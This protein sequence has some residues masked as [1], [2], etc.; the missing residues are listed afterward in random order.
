[1]NIGDKIKKLRINKGLTQ[2][3]L[4]DLC[5][6]ADS[7]IRRYESGKVTPK[8]N[9][10]KKLSYALDISINEL[11]DYETIQILTE[12]DEFE[13]TYN[14]ITTG[15]LD[16]AIIKLLSNFNFAQ[17]ITNQDFG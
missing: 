14:N 13:K 9:T 5:G 10:L 2:K 15:N 12:I 7:A 11:A 1:M 6:I 4:G 3:Q 8:L 16:T 17:K